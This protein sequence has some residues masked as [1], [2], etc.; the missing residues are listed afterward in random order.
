[1]S[2]IKLQKDP[3]NVI[4]TGVGGQGNVMAS[5]LLSKVLVQKGFKVTIGETFGASQRG[6]SVMTHIRVS[7]DTVWSPQ[8]PKG[9]ADIVISSEPIETIRILKGYGNQNVKVVMNTR[10]IYP[11]G[12]LAGRDDYPDLENIKKTV[13][14]LS[15]RA[16]FVDATDEAMKLGN[17]ILSNII[18]MGIVCTMGDLPLDPDAFKTAMSNAFPAKIHEQNFKAFDLGIEMF[19]GSRTM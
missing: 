11:V 2:K 18:M 3:Y 14:N 16:W 13:K 9:K 19:N 17:P 1:M 10:P 4:F 12:V 15:A 6:G 5:R 8:M 7:S